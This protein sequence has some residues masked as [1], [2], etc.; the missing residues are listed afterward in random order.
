MEHHGFI[1]V[2]LDFLFRGP[3]SRT[4]GQLVMANV[5]Q[6]FLIPSGIE[7][8]YEATSFLASSSSHRT[9]DGSF[10]YKICQG[11]RLGGGGS[12]SGFVSA[13]LYLSPICLYYYLHCTF[14]I[15]LLGHYASI[16]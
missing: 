9:T 16:P 4:F 1:G 5:S 8:A 15:S 11:S 6:N 2:L 14:T 12:G 7:Y 10:G 13:D 3:S